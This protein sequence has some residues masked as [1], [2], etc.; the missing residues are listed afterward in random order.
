MRELEAL[1]ILWACETY[2]GLI[3]VIIGA[4]FTEETDH[5]SLQGLNN[6]QKPARI[7]RW[8]L[9]LAEFDFLVKYKRGREWHRGSEPAPSDGPAA[10]LL[11]LGVEQAIN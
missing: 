7:V 5:E 8:A 6:A 4:P 10:G 3:I 1:A 9:R 11:L 2:D